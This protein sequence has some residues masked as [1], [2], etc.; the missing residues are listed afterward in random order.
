MKKN[1]F[2][3]GSIVDAPYFTNRSEEIKKVKTIL[4]SDNHLIIISPRRFGKTSLI[5][6]V[7]KEIDRP[8]IFLD[9][10]L[11]TNTED[12]AAQLLKRVYRI[13]PVKYSD[14]K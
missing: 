11:I 12:F 9:L 14:V 3:F 6:K 2:K 5:S 4:A 13:Y 10:Q 7:I 1:P 8:V